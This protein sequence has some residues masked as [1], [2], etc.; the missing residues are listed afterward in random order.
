M[1][2]KLKSDSSDLEKMD[3][4]DSDDLKLKKKGGWSIIDHR[5]LFSSDGETLFIVWTETIKAYGSQT[6][7]LLKEFEP[8]DNRLVSLVMDPD[9]PNTVIGC[10]S[11]GHLTFWDCHS[12]LISSNLKLELDETKDLKIK[13]F[14]ILKYKNEK[15][16]PVHHALVSYLLKD[17]KTIHLS[18]FH[19][20]DG[21]CLM[22]KIIT[23]EDSDFHVDIVGNHGNNLIPV[24]QK[25][26]I[27]ILDP[28]RNLKREVHK[29][30]RTIT[31]VA[32]HPD[33][34]SVAVGDSSG[35]VLLLTNLYS[36]DK[37][38][39][40]VRPVQTV[41]HWHTLPVA[42]IAFSQSGNHMYTG[43]GERVLVKWTNPEK[44]SFLPRL[45]EPIKHITIGP[46]NI[47]IAVSTLDNGISIV[48]PQL[49]FTSVIQKFT[50]RVETSSKN[51]F[52]AGLT[53]DPRTSSLILNSRTGHV[54]FYDTQAE[55]LL[56]NVNI[57]LQNIISQER[58]A[59]IVNTEV[60]KI[61]LNYDGTW[62]ATA[63]ERE[64]VVSYTEVRLKFWNFDSKN[65]TFVLNTSIELPHRFGINALMFQPN[66]SLSG[67]NHFA[68]TS[69]KD[70]TFKLW[71]LVDPES[72]YKQTKHWQC[73]SVGSYKERPSSDVAFSICGSLL[74]VG[75]DSDLTL[76]NP[77]SMEMKY[78]F[79]SFLCEQ[80]IT[81]VEFGKQHES[82]HLVISGSKE[83]IA[84]WN[85][86]NLRLVW[87]VPLK[88]C[89]IV[90]DPNSSYFA[91]FT[92]DNFLFVFSPENP[93]YIYKRSNV[94][95]EAS[96][97]AG[98]A[99]IPLPREKKTSELNRWQR[100]SQL[101]FLDSNQELW[102]LE[103]E[104]S[105]KDSFESLSMSRS[106]PTTAFAR[107][108]AAETAS[109]REQF[110]P[111]V[112][113]GAGSSLE[114]FVEKSLRD[115]HAHTLPPERTI[116]RD[117]MMSFETNLL[118]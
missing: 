15:G 26:T 68:V 63:E 112:H 11:T 1:I 84:V 73:V 51:L 100:K 59:V 80:T 75:F 67:Y 6:G 47:Y 62:L 52:P 12:G 91:A 34:Q 97:I 46:E 16:K 104:S 88:L 101:Y 50:R 56:Y 53:A 111:F 29:V 17:P 58:N 20:K 45:S 57:T 61:A 39:K 8:A 70:N 103:S 110:D 66:T 115:S 48:N 83:H 69:G 14:H 99:F 114:N 79:C 10:I 95:G 60:T 65:Q 36:R 85:I 107:I 74:A 72:S 4:S 78:C 19:M 9:C 38:E 113:E 2:L 44:K 106:L 41:Y 93:N 55:K 33:N 31:C 37:N 43:G 40:L 102:T 89:S 32:G 86:L 109:S 24:C 92:T 118:R 77:E 23:G 7:D 82:C 81:H 116:S 49:R 96:S 105:S 71:K 27:F 13:S 117:F 35:R 87:V 90:A 25:N 42:V 18:V 108:V 22:S 5:P 54:Q 28:T 94:V 76:W 21:H 30:S 64:D 3:I 98:A